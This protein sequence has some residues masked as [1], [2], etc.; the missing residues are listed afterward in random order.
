[1]ADQA[2]GEG[3]AGVVVDMAVFGTAIHR[4]GDTVVYIDTVVVCV[5][6][7]LRC[8]IVCGISDS[9]LSIVDIGKISHCIAVARLAHAATI[10]VA[11]VY[12]GIV[13]L[14]ISQWL[15]G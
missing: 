11:I 15:V 9:N 10:E 4:T 14:I 2:I 5:I 1:M 6:I 12:A 7:V 13:N 3:N 8:G